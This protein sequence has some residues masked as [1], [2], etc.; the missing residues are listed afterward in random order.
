M[1]PVVSHRKINRPSQDVNTFFFCSSPIF[2]EENRLS[3]NVKTFFFA[4][5]LYPSNNLAGKG[6]HFPTR[7][8][9]T[10]EV[11]HPCFNIYRVANFLFNS[12]VNRNRRV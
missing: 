5:H 3:E 8:S 9:P 4:L 7:G 12:K 2:L 10:E 1:R 6:L 11:A